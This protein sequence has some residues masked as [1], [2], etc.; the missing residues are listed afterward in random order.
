MMVIETRCL[1]ASTRRRKRAYVIQPNQPV[2][3]ITLKDAMA[4]A[5]WFGHDL[6]TEE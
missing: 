5:H 4:D 1:L 6:P 3:M 2:R